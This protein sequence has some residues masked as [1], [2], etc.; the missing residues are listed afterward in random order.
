MQEVTAKHNQ[1]PLM[2][3]EKSI[4]GHD[5]LLQNLNTGCAVNALASDPCQQQRVNLIL[6]ISIILSFFHVN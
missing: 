2:S 3:M 5:S 6:S 1:N 4:A